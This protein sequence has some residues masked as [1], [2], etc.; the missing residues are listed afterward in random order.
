MMEGGG[1]G[2]ARGPDP[3]FLTRPSTL[4]KFLVL[5]TLEWIPFILQNVDSGPPLKIFFLDL[6]L[7]V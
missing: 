4:C 6:P 3:T 5:Y 1:G 7:T 2:P